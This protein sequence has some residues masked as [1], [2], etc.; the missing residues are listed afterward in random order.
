LREHG[1]EKSGTH[2]PVT[3]HHVPGEWKPHL[4]MLFRNSKQI[5]HME[6]FAF[7]LYT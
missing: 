6:Q 5:T 7:I 1:F 2:Y 3:Q 4:T